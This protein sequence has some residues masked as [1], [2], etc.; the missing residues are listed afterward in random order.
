[1]IE[2]STQQRHSHRE[3]LSSVQHR[4]HSRHNIRHHGHHDAD[5]HDRSP[6]SKGVQRVKNEDGS[7]LYPDYLP[8]YDPL[9]K[10]EDIGEFEHFDPG[11]RADYKL[12]NLLATATKV[13]DLS[14]HVGTEIYGVQLSKLSPEGLNELA[15]YAA[16]RGALVFRDQDF[17]DIGFEGQK[18]IV[19]HFGPLHIHGLCKTPAWPLLNVDQEWSLQPR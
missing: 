10:V 5:H 13:F 1:M 3:D 15:L 6:Q 9:E 19:S 2:H 14:P 11:H 7:A 12:P 18:K 4:Y 8:F 17:R 16:Q